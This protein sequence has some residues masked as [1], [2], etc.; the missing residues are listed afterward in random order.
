[1]SKRHVRTWNYRVVRHKS[2]LPNFPD[3][4]QIHEV[5]YEADKPV[6]VSA[7]AARVGGETLAEMRWVLKKIEAALAKPILDYTVFDK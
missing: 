6:G 5:H 3:Y 4:L 2:Q 7:V 1:M